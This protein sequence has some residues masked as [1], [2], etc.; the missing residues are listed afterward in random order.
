M[1]AV[2]DRA[3]MS[4]R[5]LAQR[6]GYTVGQIQHFEAGRRTATGNGLD[7]LTRAL[8]LSSWEIQYLYALGGRVSAES[9]GVVDIAS[10]L[11]AIE[12]HPAAW[13]DAGWTVQESNEAFRRLF[14]GLWMTPNLV[15]WHY[16]SVKA[17]DVIQNWN[18]TSEWCVGLLRF[19]IAAAPKDPGLQEVISSLMPIRAFR[20]QWDAQII[21]VDPATRPWILRDLESRELLTVD[22]RAWH[23]RS[24]SGML[25]FGAVI[26]RQANQQP[27]HQPLGQTPQ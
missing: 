4:Q 9:T 17:R 11:Q 15:H 24:T 23:T 6:T 12:P 8:N 3:Q 2:R 22:M 7:S 26:D 5:Q 21:P 18:E 16:H 27:H 13:M 25:L 20:T 19:G 10:Y 14:P 1:R